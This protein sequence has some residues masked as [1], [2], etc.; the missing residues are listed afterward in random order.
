VG[1]A[2]ILLCALCDFVVAYK[3]MTPKALCT[4]SLPT[5]PAA[6]S[7]TPRKYP[8]ELT[9]L[10]TTRVVPAA[11]HDFFNH[12]PCGHAS[13]INYSQKVATYREEHE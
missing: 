10:A 11:H 3:K 12:K 4:F 9:T 2:G 6:F 13:Q 7:N 1:F 8:Q 5:N